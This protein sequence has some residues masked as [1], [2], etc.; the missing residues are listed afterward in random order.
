LSVFFPEE[1]ADCLEISAQHKFVSVAED[2][3]VKVYSFA[4]GFNLA[5]QLYYRVT[6]RNTEIFLKPG[7][8]GDGQDALFTP[9][10]FQAVILP[11]DVEQ[12]FIFQVSSDKAGEIDVWNHGD[13]KKYW[14]VVHQPEPLKIYA[15]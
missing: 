15:P 10:Y 1:P 5:V 9:F 12:G 2:L 6:G 14:F 3:A 4:V 7:V 13:V 11:Q 8:S